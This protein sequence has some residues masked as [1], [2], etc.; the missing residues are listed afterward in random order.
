LNLGDIREEIFIP[1]NSGCYRSN[2]LNRN[3][4]LEIQEEASTKMRLVY[5][6]FTA[7]LS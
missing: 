1:P 3:L 5:W 7:F 6:L 2:P 4:A